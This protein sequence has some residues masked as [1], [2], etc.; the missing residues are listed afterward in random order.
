MFRGASVDISIVLATYNESQNLPVLMGKLELIG[1]L[2]K[3]IIFVDDGSTDKTRDMIL[4]YS[5]CN[6]VTK[7]I[8]NEGKQSTLKAQ[9]QGILVSDSEF[10]VVMDSD[11]QHPPELIR[12]IYE[13]LQNGYDIVTASRFTEKGSTG[14]RVPLRG[15]ISRVASFITK[16]LLRTARTTSDPM[17]GYFGFRRELFKPINNEWRGYK[18][19][20][21]VRAE[22]PRARVCDIPYVFRERGNGNSNVVNGISFI[23]LF[24]TELIH[25]KKVELM[26]S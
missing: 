25:V 12:A 10:V 22:N 8:F 17:S 4:K 16:L 18:M 1:E 6:P 7:Y 9:A 2:R 24:L 15:L 26:N 23:R 21:L 5:N 19:H 14:N 3:Q 11:L 20:L 13:K